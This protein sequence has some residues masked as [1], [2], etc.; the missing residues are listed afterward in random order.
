MQPAFGSAGFHSGTPECSQRSK[1]QACRSTDS[2]CVDSGAEGTLGDAKPVGQIRALM[3][4][5]RSLCLSIDQSC[6]S[7]DPVRAVL[8][9]ARLARL[10]PI[11]TTLL[12]LMTDSSGGACA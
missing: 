12:V 6:V 1:L 2:R 7:T 9:T 4:R 11:E 10:L 5:R 8:E 3:V